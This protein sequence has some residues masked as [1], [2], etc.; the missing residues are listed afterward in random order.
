MRPEVHH[1]IWYNG[2]QVTTMLRDFERAVEQG[3]VSQE[4]LEELKAAAS[5]QGGR[6]AEAKAAAKAADASPDASRQ[7]C[8]PSALDFCKILPQWPLC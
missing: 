5:Q 2:V 8:L 1:L 3:V 6:V 7:V 4:Q